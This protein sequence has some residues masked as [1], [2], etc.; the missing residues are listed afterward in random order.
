[1]CK[2]NSLQ[3]ITNFLRDKNLI[4]INA[5]QKLSSVYYEIIKFAV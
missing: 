3:Q 2:Y 5:F 1:M 4:F